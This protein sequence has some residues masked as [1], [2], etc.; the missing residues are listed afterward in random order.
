MAFLVVITGHMLRFTFNTDAITFTA[1][2]LGGAVLLARVALAVGMR[3]IATFVE[4]CALLLAASICAVSLTVLVSTLGLP[5]ADP[6]MAAVD[7]VLLP[8][9][10]RQMV[11]ALGPRHDLVTVMCAIYQSLNWQPFVLMAALAIKADE[12]TVWRFAHAWCLALALSVAIFAIAPSVTAYV[13]YGINPS[14]M[15]ALTVNAGWRPAEVLHAIRDGSLREVTTFGVP[16][17]ITFPSFHA[18]GAMLLAWGFSKI[19]PFGLIFVSLN[20]A[21]LPC[22]PAIGSHYFVDVIG[23]IIVAGTSLLASSTKRASSVRESASG[24]M[25]NCGPA[26][27]SL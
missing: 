11:E 16:G 27:A 6:A 8:F 12:L 18:A 15:P 4:S 19:R 3:I 10:W 1:T 14:A 22:I 26:G 24:K 2:A 25:I 9:S 17:L 23:G 5:Y 7:N 21:M 13:H 20:V